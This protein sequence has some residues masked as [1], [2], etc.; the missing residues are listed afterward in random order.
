M[1]KLLGLLQLV[2]QKY[3]HVQFA[4]RDW[5]LIQVEYAQHFVTIHFNALASQSGHICL[6]RSADYVNNRMRSQLVLFVE[7]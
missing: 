3:Q 1:K 4:W 5:T 6:A 7:H 2:V